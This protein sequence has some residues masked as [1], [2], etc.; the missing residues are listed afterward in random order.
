M[1]IRQIFI[2]GGILVLTSACMPLGTSVVEGIQG[3]E[4]VQ[5]Q[6]ILLVEHFMNTDCRTLKLQAQTLKRSVTNPLIN[7]YGGAANSQNYKAILVAI[8]RKGCV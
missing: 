2:C 3:K 6:Q 8:E 7:L 4:A 1:N 5:A